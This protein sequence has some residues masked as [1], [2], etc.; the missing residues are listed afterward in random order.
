MPWMKR[1]WKLESREIYSIQ[2]H[3]VLL[4]YL[5]R[6]RDGNGNEDDEQQKR[7]QINSNLVADIID[8]H[9]GWSVVEW[10]DFFSTILDQTQDACLDEED[11]CYP[12]SNN[13]NCSA[14]TERSEC[15]RVISLDLR[16]ARPQNKCRGTEGF[17]NLLSFFTHP[18]DW[19]PMPC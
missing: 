13:G 17:L 6:A 19:W 2:F 1:K 10:Y 18:H 5:L 3:F 8:G 4:I 16:S 9:P 12:Q 11:E 14:H 15:K 7:M